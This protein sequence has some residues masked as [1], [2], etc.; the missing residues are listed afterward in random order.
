[1]NEVLEL[2]KEGCEL[3]D[4]DMIDIAVGI[5]KD[6]ESKYAQQVE[7]IASKLLE[8]GWDDSSA[9]VK[10]LESLLIPK[11]VV[12]PEENHSAI[13][14]TFENPITTKKEP[15]TARN[16]VNTFNP[17]EYKNLFKD[18]DHQSK[19]AKSKPLKKPDYDT[20]LVETDCTKCGRSFEVARE[21][22]LGEDFGNVCD[23]CTG[24]S[25]KKRKR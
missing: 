20:T 5:V 17:E 10:T 11:A 14:Q 25:S 23:K 24:G 19:K 18:E 21:F 22:Y 1:M 16:R 15:V 8:K 6:S 7:K 13:K 9:L 12:V 3:Q 2:I 4:P